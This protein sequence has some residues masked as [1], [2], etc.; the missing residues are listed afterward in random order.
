MLWSQLDNIRQQLWA[1]PESTHGLSHGGFNLQRCV[2]A[3]LP[4]L[5]AAPAEYLLICLLEV[6][7]RCR[8]DVDSARETTGGSML[9]VF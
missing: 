6:A 3:H 4:K 8:Q 5:E 9:D 1:L 7:G 2:A